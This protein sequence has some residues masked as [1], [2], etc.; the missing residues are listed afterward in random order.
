MPEAKEDEEWISWIRHFEDCTV[1][2]GKALQVLV[3]AATRFSITN[4][5]GIL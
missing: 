2:P 5:A 1:E 3:R 4:L